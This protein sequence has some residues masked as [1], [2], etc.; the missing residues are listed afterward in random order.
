[1]VV[2]ISNSSKPAS[3][4]KIASLGKYL[5]RFSAK[6]YKSTLSEYFLSSSQSGKIFFQCRHFSTHFELTEKS[7]CSKI[8]SKISDKFPITT[9]SI[10]TVFFLK[11]LGFSKILLQKFTIALIF[12]YKR[13]SYHPPRPS[14]IREGAVRTPNVQHSFP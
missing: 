2:G 11:T 7:A 9:K 5:D 13:F 14:L 8:R 4:T 6:K 1:M 3:Q 12:E 10:F